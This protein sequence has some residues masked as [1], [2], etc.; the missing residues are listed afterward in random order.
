LLASSRHGGSEELLGLGHGFGRQRLASWAGGTA[1]THLVHRFLETNH[2]KGTYQ[3]G[4]TH[5][6]RSFDMIRTSETLY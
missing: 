4:N 3:E 1:V 5:R 2:M 6:H